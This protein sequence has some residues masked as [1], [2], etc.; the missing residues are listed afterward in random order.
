LA[1]AFRAI[2]AA[3]PERCRLIDADGDVE[4]VAD[5]VLAAVEAAGL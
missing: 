2:A 1:E 3:H 5:R 4:L